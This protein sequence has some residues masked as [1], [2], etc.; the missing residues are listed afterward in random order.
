MLRATTASVSRALLPALLVLS[1][2]C[3]GQG[4]RVLGDWTFTVTGLCDAGSLSLTEID[5]AGFWDTVWGKWTC[6]PDAPRDVEVAV[7]D[8]G[9]VLVIFLAKPRTVVPFVYQWPG[10]SGNWTDDTIHG[11]AD[12]GSGAVF[13][14]TRVSR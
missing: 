5:G 14:A 8:D 7:F 6:G 10:F 1:F 9:G 11:T 13:H 4:G 3:H 2:A 12:D